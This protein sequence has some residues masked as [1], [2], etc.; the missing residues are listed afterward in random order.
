MKPR[1]LSAFVLMVVLPTA[2]LGLLAVRALRDRERLLLQSAV[3]SARASI[4]E[5]TRSLTSRLSDDLG[6]IRL[7][8]T[9][10]LVRGWDVSQAGTSASRLKASLP[11]VEDVYVFMNP[12][13]FLLPEEGR[14]QARGSDESQAMSRGPAEEAEME[15]PPSAV[16]PLARSEHSERL[17]EEL[18]ARIAGSDPAGALSFTLEGASYSFVALQERRSLY[19]GCRYNPAVVRRLVEEQARTYRGGMYRIAVGPAASGAGPVRNDGD[20]IVVAPFGGGAAGREDLWRAAVGR[21]G[22]VLAE[23]AL[24][25]PLEGV[26][27][28]ALMDA[29]AAQDSLE[30]SR[31]GLLAWAMVLLTAAILA[32]AGLVLMDALGR[33]GRA[34]ARSHFIAGISHDLRTPIAAVRMLSESLVLGRVPDP[35]KQN[36][37]LDRIMRETRRLEDLVDRV[38]FLVKFGQGS[39]ALASQPVDV[40]GVIRRAAESIEGRYLGDV[41]SGKLCVDAR[42]AADLLP[43]AGDR[44]ALEQVVMNLL[45]NAVKYG[46]G[47]GAG[48]SSFVIGGKT[49][50]RMDA[51]E[52]E[53]SDTGAPLATVEADVAS[54][55]DWRRRGSYV[56]ISVTD[57]GPGLSRSELRRLFRPFYRTESARAANLSGVGLG[58][59]MSREIVKRHGGWMEVSSEKGKGSVFSVFLPAG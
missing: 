3:S 53:V 13:G 48:H 7:A 9:D 41:S 57:R 23:G 35:A 32:G 59:A 51:A 10:C 12:W 15:L 14:R 17:V 19:V 28:I 4:G 45:D 20:V 52:T 44:G 22:Q 50:D 37:F 30:P 27:L 33:A 38:L 46:A 24:P 29:T 21:R 58:L 40:S 25:A 36:A 39:M 42:V 47:K 18:R 6:R 11:A 31:T 55:R 54:V 43:V 2:V 34:E 26:K 16:P 49:G 56:R 5:M 1:L 8:M